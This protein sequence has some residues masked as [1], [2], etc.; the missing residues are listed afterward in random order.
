MSKLGEMLLLLEKH[1]FTPK[2]FT[3]AKKINVKLSTSKNF[4]HG[5]LSKP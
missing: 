2:Y 1:I 4:G 5:V 3:I